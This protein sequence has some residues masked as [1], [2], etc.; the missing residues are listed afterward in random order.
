MQISEAIELDK[1]ERLRKI[2]ETLSKIKDEDQREQTKEDLMAL[3]NSTEYIVFDDSKKTVMSDCK[4]QYEIDER[5][6][7]RVHRICIK[8]GLGRYLV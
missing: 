2:D 1:Q 7:G 8:C 5:L 6:E 4:H 3:H